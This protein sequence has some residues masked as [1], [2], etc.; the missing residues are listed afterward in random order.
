M[1]KR[2]TELADIVTEEDFGKAQ[3]YNLDKARFGFIEGIYKQLES[4]LMLH[5]DVLPKIWDYSGELLFKAT[6]YG[7][8][9]EVIYTSLYVT[10][11]FL[12]K[13][14]LF[15]DSSITC[16]SCFV[17]INFNRYSFAFQSLLYFCC[18]RKTW[19]Q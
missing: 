9:Y 5:Y 12:T 17:Y 3:L 6:G 8:N 18:R 7:T 2:P 16:F 19:I 1:P 14:V 13:R 4:V 10:F 15:L 11:F